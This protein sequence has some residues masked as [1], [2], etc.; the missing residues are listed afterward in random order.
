VTFRTADER[1]WAEV[2][3]LG[4]YGVLAQPFDAN[5]VKRVAKL[6]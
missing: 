5:E 2:L 4:G 3:N 1:L 6:A